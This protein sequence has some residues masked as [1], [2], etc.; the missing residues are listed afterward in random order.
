M[1]NWF[2]ALYTLAVLAATPAAADRAA[3][4]A[5]QAGDMRRLVLHAEPQPMPQ[6]P[7]A[8]LTDEPRDLDEWRGQWIVVNFWATWCAPCRKEMP[9]LDALAAIGLPVITVATGRNPVPAIERFWAET[10]IT[11]LPALRDPKS[12]M[13]RQMG[14]FGLPV[15]V[16][17]D[18]AGQEVARL[19]GDADWS[20][21]EARAVISALKE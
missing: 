13:A 2:A 7:L 14:I 9:T 17:L 8:G 6:V 20:S 10:G 19:T 3:A 4:V 15:T 12:A 5:A 16:I 1:R 18:P 11:H 21:P